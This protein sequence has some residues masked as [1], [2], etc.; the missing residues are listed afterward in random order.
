MAHLVHN[1]QVKLRAGIVNN[2]G[3]AFIGGG[4]I[5]PL[6]TGQFSLG[7]AIL[8]VIWIGVGVYLHRIARDLEDLREEEK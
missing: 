6:V 2:A 5:T 1:E 4:V 7:R 3:L 8:S